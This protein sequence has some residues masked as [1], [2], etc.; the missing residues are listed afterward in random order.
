MKVGLELEEGLGGRDVHPTNGLGPEGFEGL[1][2]VCQLG[3]RLCDFL[4]ECLDLFGGEGFRSFSNGGFDTAHARGDGF[5]FLDDEL[6]EVAGVAG[7]GAAT[8]FHRVAVEGLGF[9]TD[10]HDAN[11]VAVF[12]AKEL[13]DVLA[14]FDVG[15]GDFFP[16]DR[17]GCRDGGVDFFL[18]GGELLGS[19]GRG[20][21]VEAQAVGSDQRAL[22]GGVL[23]D[24]FVQGP[25]EKVGGGVV[26]PR[27]GDGVRQRLAG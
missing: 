12:V 16:R 6:V 11:E 19:E 21:E 17:L 13:H 8:E 4:L 10:L 9:A 26:G 18:D 2:G 22:L 7:V 24:D 27:W 15:M 1:V 3:A 20:G 23:G 14:S 5:F 25:V